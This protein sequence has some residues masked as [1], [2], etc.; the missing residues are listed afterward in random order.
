MGAQQMPKEV[1]SDKSLRSR[2]TN[3]N[4]NNNTRNAID[5]NTTNTNTSTSASTGIGTG[6]GPPFNHGVRRPPRRQTPQ[7]P[8]R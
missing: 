3:T 8:H 6:T 2:P 4:T 7:N 1:V 5:T